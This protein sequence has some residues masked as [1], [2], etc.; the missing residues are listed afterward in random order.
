[1]GG[2]WCAAE[3][4]GGPY[5]PRAST[6]SR[7]VVARTGAT[8]VVGMDSDRRE[9]TKSVRWAGVAGEGWA[10]PPCVR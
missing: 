7:I 1:M 5:P 4:G 10:L 8:T 2:K 3:S 6:S 9:G